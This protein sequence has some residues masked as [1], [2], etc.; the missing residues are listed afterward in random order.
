MSIDGFLTFLGLLVAGFALLDEVSKLRIL[1]H[2]KRQVIAFVI[3]FFLVTFLIL[4]ENANENVPKIYPAYIADLVV[5]SDSTTIGSGGIAFLLVMAW[6]VVACVFYKASRPSPSA[7][8]RLSIL[9]ERLEAQGRFIELIDLVKPFLPVIVKASSRKFIRQRIHDWLCSGGPFSSSISDIFQP[10]NAESNCVSRFLRTVR[11]RSTGIARPIVSKLAALVPAM[12]KSTAGAKDLE[13]LLLRSTGLRNHLV[14]S[15][16]DFIIDLMKFPESETESFLSDMIERMISH[17]DSHFYRELDLMDAR[18]AGDSFI[19]EDQIVLMKSL[20]LDSQFASRHE[21][22]NPVFGGLLKIV[23]NDETYRQKLLKPCEDGKS[24][25]GDPTY[26][27]LKFFSAMVSR[28]A[29]S[30]IEKHMWLMLLSDLALKLSDIH[31]SWP[32]VRA[33]NEFPTLAMRLLFEITSVQ[34]DWIDLRKTLPDDNFHNSKEEIERSDGASII[35]C[36]ACDYALTIRNILSSKHLPERF[37]QDRW[38]SF[39]RTISEVPLNSRY[40]FLR[41]MLISE[42]LNPQHDYE[43]IGDLKPQLRLIHSGIDSVV[44]A[45][46]KDLERALS[47]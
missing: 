35:I 46:T 1:L 14:S 28:A 8:S 11:R 2:L 4:P 43:K 17:P 37:K 39:A 26:C 20:A 24:L 40:C 18:G 19:R 10:L 47:S 22:W 27:A 25:L 12:R 33:E 3:F 32:A 9:A 13:I 7:L 44:R 23:K 6:V 30:G 42:A 31:C 36:A 15:N 5:W 21:V 16:A 29:S 45:Q 41:S 34:K 38:Q